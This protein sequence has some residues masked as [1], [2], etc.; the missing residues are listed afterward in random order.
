MFKLNETLDDEI[1]LDGHTFQLDLAFDNVLDVFD[2]FREETDQ[3]LM[4]Y[5]SLQL[6]VINEDKPDE[7]N[8][9]LDELT[10]EQ[11][12]E[13]LN[14]IIDE[15]I[16]TDNRQDIV[17]YDLA[18]NEMKR[19]RSSGD[20]DRVVSFTWDAEYIWTS[21]IQSYQ[22]DLHNEFGRLHWRKFMALFR[23]LPS[24]T[25]IK[26]I[27]EIRTWEPDKETSAKERQ[28]MQKLQDEFELP[29]ED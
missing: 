16:N 29:E 20:D 8:P 11:A 10:P 1:E 24:E 2:L 28:R 23:D 5:G 7:T 12:I 26:Q 21:F 27:I 6:L 22:I 19:P 14:R 4:I 3:V 13:L 17:E 18:G 9:E 15:H 25:K